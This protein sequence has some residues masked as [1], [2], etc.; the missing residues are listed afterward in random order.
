MAKAV[1]LYAVRVLNCQGSGTDSGVIGGIDWVTRNARKPAVANMS[2]G[3]GASAAVDQSVQNSIAS[4]VTYAVAAGNDGGN[5]CLSSPA[6]VGAAITVGATGTNDAKTSWSSYGTCLD[7][8]APGDGIT[9]AWNTSNTATNTISGTSMATP[10]VAGVA[11]LYLAANPQATPAQVGSALVNNATSGVV[12]SPG[13]GSP[14]KLLYSL[15]GGTEPPPPGKHFESAGPVNIPDYPADAVDSPIS[16]S[17]VTGNAP[18]ALKVGVNITHTWRGDL[19]VDLVA[20]GGAVF[21]LHNRTG[22]S[23]DNVVGTFTVNAA[24]SPANGTWKLRVKD[25]EGADT[26]TIQKWTLDF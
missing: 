14:N 4:G 21:N 13:A 16:V 15:F 7:V 10:H 3:G 11:A 24:S 17:G 5:A 23:A 6:R 12:S 18:A 25:M 8:F 20:P 19:V 2:L 22:G 1:Q 26:G 9:S